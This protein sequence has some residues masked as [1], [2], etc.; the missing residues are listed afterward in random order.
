MFIKNKYG[1]IA[2][3]QILAILGFCWYTDWH[4]FKNDTWMIMTILLF[5]FN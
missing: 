3:I 2:I 5:I 4:P 1:P